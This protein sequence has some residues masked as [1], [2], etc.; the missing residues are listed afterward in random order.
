MHINIY[1][2]ES[3]HGELAAVCELCEL[4]RATQRCP[5]P[6]VSVTGSNICI[7]TM[8]VASARTRVCGAPA[9]RNDHHSTLGIKQSE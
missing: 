6:P 2:R 5:L 7:S 1:G 8:V 9:N 3:G 4:R